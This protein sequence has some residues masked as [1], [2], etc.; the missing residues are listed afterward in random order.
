M[1]NYH[2]VCATGVSWGLVTSSSLY[3]RSEFICYDEY[4]Y[5]VSKKTS[6]YFFSRPY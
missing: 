4:Y 2:T 5:T 6:D 3:N 1:R